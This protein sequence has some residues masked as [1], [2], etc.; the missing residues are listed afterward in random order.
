MSTTRWPDRRALALAALLGGCLLVACTVQ[1]PG[2]PVS[3]QIEVSA[4]QRVDLRG[5]AEL[6]IEVGPAHSL[7]IDGPQNYVDSLKTRVEGETLII[8]DSQGWWGRSKG[9]AVHMRLTTPVLSAV[10]ISG[11]ADTR[12]TGLAGGDLALALQGAG[13]VQAGGSVANLAV[14]MSGAG[15][16]EL[17]ELV[18]QNAAA[19]LNGA[20]NMELN[21][22][23]NLD[24]T[25][26]GVGNIEY[27][28]N[29]AQVKT[30]MNG[31][32]SIKA[33]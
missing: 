12:I 20:G 2:P 29:P 6:Q 25:V 32:G 13:H 9:G 14:S 27:R 21:V 22:T 15:S 10:S 18:A 28:G 31:V 23:G 4:F 16:L 30:A 24:A 26:N 5:A 3:R 7:H 11:A 17:D 19:T 33:K 1:E 8:E